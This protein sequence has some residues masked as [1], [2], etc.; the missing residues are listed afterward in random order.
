[1][2]QDNFKSLNPKIFLITFNIF[3]KKNINIVYVKIS[4][5][6]VFFGDPI[7]ITAQ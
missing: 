1:M 6:N 5:F 3:Y 2:I 4:V 7:S